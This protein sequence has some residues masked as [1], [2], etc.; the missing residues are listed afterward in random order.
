MKCKS[1]LRIKESSWLWKCFITLRTFILVTFIKVL[2][3]V[4]TLTQG[5]GLWK[6]AFSEHTF[7]LS[8]PRLLP[9]LSDTDVKQTAVVFLFV[10][11]WFVFSLVQRKRMIREYFSKWPTPVRILIMALLFLVIFRFGGKLS[12]EDVFMYAGF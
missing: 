12:S 5:F 1:A 6:R 4:G 2:P 7:S 11:L 3:E 9:F 8:I 10:G